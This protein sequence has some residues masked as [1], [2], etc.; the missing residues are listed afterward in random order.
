MEW[1]LLY[2]DLP[3]IAHLESGNTAGSRT[4]LNYH[5][6]TSQFGLLLVGRCRASNDTSSFELLVVGP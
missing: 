6:V 3:V 1:L 2:E 4:N 5:K